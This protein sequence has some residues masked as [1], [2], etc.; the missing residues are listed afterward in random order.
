MDLKK[1]TESRGL[2]SQPAFLGI[3]REVR[4]GFW[5]YSGVLHSQR[6]TLGC[7]R[8]KQPQ[9]TL[10]HHL[11]RFSSLRGFPRVALCRGERR[12]RGLWSRKRLPGHLFPRALI[13]PATK[14]TEVLLWRVLSLPGLRAHS[15]RSRN[16]PHLKCVHCRSTRGTK[17]RS[18][19]RL[20]ASPDHWI[21]TVA[22]RMLP[23]PCLHPFFSLSPAVNQTSQRLRQEEDKLAIGQLI[24]DETNNP[25]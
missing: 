25:G 17:R 1:G 9:V 11:S 15:V 5:K 21:G 4:A 19:G 13:V 22:L 10:H 24:S 8:A 14:H 2:R 20:G 18:A 7:G 12:E 6:W 16:W 23:R 3:I